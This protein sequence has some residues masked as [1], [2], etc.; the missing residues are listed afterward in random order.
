MK[1][2]VDR[3]KGFRLKVLKAESQRL[4]DEDWSSISEVL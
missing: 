2:A 4:K 1:V 3:L